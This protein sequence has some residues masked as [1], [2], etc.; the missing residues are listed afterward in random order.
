MK[1][2][3]N[4]K[5]KKVFFYGKMQWAYINIFTSTRP[6]NNKDVAINYSKWYNKISQ[7]VF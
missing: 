3:I 7:F 1:K 6:Y 4:A 2:N 5:T